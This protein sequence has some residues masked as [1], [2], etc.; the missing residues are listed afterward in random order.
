[1]ARSL[2]KLS[3]TGPLRKKL[4]RDIIVN[5]GFIWR[6]FRSGDEYAIY[7]TEE[8]DAVMAIQSS[9]GRMTFTGDWSDLVIP[10]ELLPHNDVFVSASPP[11]VIELLKEHY[12][13]AGE[14]PC[15]HF[16]YPAGYG[17]GEWD[18]LGPLTE[19]DVAFVASHWELGGD[20]RVEHI[21]D[22]V[23]RFDSACVRMSGQPVSWCGLHFEM[24]GVGNL[25]FAHTLDQYRRK[26]FQ[27]QV[28][29]ALVNRLYRKGSRATSDVIKDNAVSFSLCKSLGCQMVGELTWADFKV[30]E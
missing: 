10:K 15:W 21:R 3:D 20:D 29:K 5:S 23:T 9:P 2:R 14:W 6:V 27:I 19:D 1:M 12:E 4:D 11:E 28:T 30:R 16:L 22:S 24:E 18:E 8:L 13:P 17:S 26:G 25:G 7:A